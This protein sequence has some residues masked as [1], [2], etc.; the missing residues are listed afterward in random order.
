MTARAGDVVQASPTL[1][2]LDDL[3]YLLQGA[4]EQEVLFTFIAERYERR[5]AGHHVKPS[6]LG[7]G[8]HLCQPH[9]HRR[10]D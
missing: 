8:T 6:L 10:G 7:V 5:I 3:G 2:L 4:E 1:L 9:G